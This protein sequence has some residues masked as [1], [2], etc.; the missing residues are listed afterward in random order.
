MAL[1]N[2]FLTGT[3]LICLC[4]QSAANLSPYRASEVLALAVKGWTRLD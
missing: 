3:N 2:G 1:D 4:A